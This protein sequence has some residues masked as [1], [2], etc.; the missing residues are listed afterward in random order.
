[1][2]YVYVLCLCICIDERVC[3]CECGCVCV[4]VFEFF[5]K[6]CVEIQYA[7]FVMYVCCVYNKTIQTYLLTQKYTH[8]HTNP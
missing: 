8:V 7:C 6:V 3:V 5:L 4:C 1:M 2:C